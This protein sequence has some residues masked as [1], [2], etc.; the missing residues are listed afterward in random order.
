MTLITTDNRTH[1]K[2]H[3]QSEKSENTLKKTPRSQPV[4]DLDLDPRADT[5]DRAINAIKTYNNDPNRTYQEKWYLSNPMVA[6]LIRSSGCQVAGKFLQ[7]YLRYRSVDLEQHHQF[8]QL[9]VRHNAKH[10]QPISH[11]ISMT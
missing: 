10:D 11:F 9:S 8:H 7:E 4:I 5:V 2:T 1:S 6:D 3:H